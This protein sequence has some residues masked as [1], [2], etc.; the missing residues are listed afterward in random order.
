MNEAGVIILI[1]QIFR[2]VFCL[3][4]LILVCN[5]LRMK[6]N[7]QAELMANSLMEIFILLVMQLWICIQNEYESYSIKAWEYAAVI[8]SLDL[9]ILLIGIHYT[10]KGSSIIKWSASAQVAALLAGT[11]IFI[12]SQGELPFAYTGLMIGMK[13]VGCFLGLVAVIMIWL[14]DSR[15]IQEVSCRKRRKIYTLLGIKGFLYVL[16]ATASVTRLTNI[17]LLVAVLQVIFN[18]TNLIFIE[19]TVI[20]EVWKKLDS[21]AKTND[22]KIAKGDTEQRILAEAA[23]TIHKDIE[24]INFRILDL[25]SELLNSNEKKSKRYIEK[26]QNNCKRLIKLSDN[27]LDYNPYKVEDKTSEFEMTN[28]ST[29]VA[30]IVES[31]ESYIKQRGITIQ[32]YSV[33]PDITAEVEKDAIERIILNLISNSVKYNVTNGKIEVIVGERE[34]KIYL[35]VKDTGI[36]IPDASQKLI[37]QKFKRVDSTLTKVQEGS[38]LGLA[39]VKSLVDLHHGKIKMVSREGQGTIMSIE[40]PKLQKKRSSKEDYFLNTKSMK[41]KVET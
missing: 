31:L 3:C 7:H 15:R 14:K 32:Y 20:E 1:G 4:S 40:I 17:Y 33:K 23:K 38:G 41:R 9:I 24:S 12:Q 11:V 29:L 18:M 37:F 34:R 19:N 27:I 13:L 6:L 39:I 36:G 35:C 10:D 22:K 16:M 30:S 8:E 25:E 21:E 5:H 28:I 26:I 2:I